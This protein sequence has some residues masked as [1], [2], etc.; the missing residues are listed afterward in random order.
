M[1]TF[2]ENLIS[3]REKNI[4]QTDIN[5]KSSLVSCYEVSCYIEF[6][7]FDGFQRSVFFE[8]DF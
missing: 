7:N 4:P 3:Q 5:V 1:G 6:G 8:T 2:D